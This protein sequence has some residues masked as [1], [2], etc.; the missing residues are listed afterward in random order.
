[1]NGEG[2]GTA[3]D[4]KMALLGMALILASQVGCGMRSQVSAANI[5][6]CR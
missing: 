4:P 6:P 1:V 5:G 2:P 3:A